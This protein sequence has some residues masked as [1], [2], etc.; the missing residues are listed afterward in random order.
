MRESAER[1]GDERLA[2]AWPVGGGNERPGEDDILGGE[3]EVS[4]VD[5]MLDRGGVACAARD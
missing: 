2:R 4:T 5:A 1:V 3:D